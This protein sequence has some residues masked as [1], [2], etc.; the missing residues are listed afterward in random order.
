M[1]IQISGTNVIDNSRNIVNT[2]SM[3]I[4]AVSITGSN[5]NITTTGT[6]TANSLNGPLE[7]VGF[8]PADGLSSWNIYSPGDKKVS[9]AFNQ[10]ISL[11]SGTATLRENSSSGTI[12]K[13]FSTSDA[14]IIGQSTLQFDFPVTDADPGQSY[15]FV[16]PAGFV[17]NSNNDQNVALT[18]YNFTITSGTLGEAFAG[19][20]L[21]CKTSNKFWVA[22]PSSTEV[23]CVFSQANTRAVNCAQAQ[24]ACGDWFILSCAQMLNPGYSCRQYWDSYQPSEYWTACAATSF[25][26]YAVNFAFGA[27]S[28]PGFN[29]EFYPSRAF[30]CFTY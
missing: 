5:G 20:Y 17:K 2:P 6:I 15:Y 13:S 27:V 26:G 4:G 21:I 18:N 16:V 3:T 1:A 24:A 7:A 19:G 28:Q 8:E 9:I 10:P 29:D 14:S 11:N 12:V 23:T 25:R 22:A 30:R